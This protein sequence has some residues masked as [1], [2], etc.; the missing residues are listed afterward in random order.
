MTPITSGR[1]G[2]RSPPPTREYSWKRILD[3]KLSSEVAAFLVDI[4]NADDYNKGKITDVSKVGIKA[5]GEYTLQVVTAKPAPQFRA[6]LALPYLTPIP[7][8][9]VEKTGEKWIAPENI[10]SNGP[11][12]LVSRVNDQSIVMEANPYYARQQADHPAHRDDDRLG[13]SLHRATA[14]L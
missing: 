12:K 5:T 13:R 9:V 10:L 2:N 7:K 6:I 11:Y 8:A 3:P 14:R 4:E 1:T